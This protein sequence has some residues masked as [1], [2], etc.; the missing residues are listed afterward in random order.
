MRLV[1]VWLAVNIGKLQ[2]LVREDKFISFLVYKLTCASCSSSG[3]GETFRH[4]KTKTK[5]H[6]KKDN[7]SYFFKHLHTSATCFDSYNSLS[8]KTIDKA[9]SK[10]DLKSKKALHI[11]Q[12]KPNLT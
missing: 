2:S 5:E 10:F 6:V 7:K 8:V 1:I 12:I 3:I 4:F 11:N 9:N